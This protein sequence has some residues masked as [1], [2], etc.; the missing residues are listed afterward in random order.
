ML[1]SM[2]ECAQ[3]DG[4]IEVVVPHLIDGGLSLLNMPMKQLHL[5]NMISKK[6][7]I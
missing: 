3:S 4:Q 5:W 7:E 6:Q 2:I 1:A